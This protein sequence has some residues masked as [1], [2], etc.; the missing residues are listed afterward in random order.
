FVGIRIST[1]R[2]VKASKPRSCHNR[3]PAGKGDGVASTMGLSGVRPPEGSLRKRIVSKALTSRTFLT[4]WS[5]FLPLSHAICAGRSWGRTMRRSVPSWA[6]GGRQYGG[7]CL[8]Q[9][10]GMLLPWRDH[11]GRSGL[12]AAELRRQGREG[13]GGGIAEGAQGREQRG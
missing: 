13:A 5:L 2:S 10:H 9:W 12:R 7:K 8:G 1:W 4:V 11:G 3:L 6:Q